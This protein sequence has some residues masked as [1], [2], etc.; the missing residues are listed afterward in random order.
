MFLFLRHD[1]VKAE[2]TM[3][4]VKVKKIPPS[5][6][7]FTAGT[8]A[9]KIRPKPIKG[10]SADAK[11][12][13]LEKEYEGDVWN[14]PSYSCKKCGV[15]VVPPA[16]HKFE[17]GESGRK[18][19]LDHAAKY[20]GEIHTP[21]GGDHIVVTKP[22]HQRSGKGASEKITHLQHGDVTIEH[23]QSKLCPKHYG[24]TSKSLDM[25]DSM[26]KGYGQKKKIEKSLY[27]AL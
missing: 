17:R 1:L 15:K 21:K 6:R 2:E 13:R 22:P 23:H 11:T 19:A 20:K 12:R 7:S 16:K 14:K 10:G 3:G 5:P 9:P 27:L 4:G 18:Q 8:P 26:L 24:Q 25:F